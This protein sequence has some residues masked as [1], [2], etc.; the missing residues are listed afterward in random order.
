MHHRG[1]HRRSLYRGSWKRP[2]N[3][4][5]VGF[6]NQGCP[7]VEQIVA[8]IVSKAL[9]QDSKLPGALIQLFSHD[10]FVKVRI[11]LYYLYHLN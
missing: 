11:A 6:Y 7:K 10:C 2:R 3:G 4:L 8:E 9:Q 5:H 1:H